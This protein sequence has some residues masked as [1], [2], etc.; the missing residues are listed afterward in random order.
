MF[1]KL[2]S[3][4][5]D[6][7]IADDWQLRV[8]F[9]DLLVLADKD[10]VVDMTAEAIARRTNV[11]PAIVKDRLAKLEAP[12]PTSRTP[13]CEGR[14]ITRIDAHRDWGWQITNFMKYRES[15]NKE[16]LRMSEADRK[17]TYRS[18]FH[19]APSPVPLTPKTEIQREKQNSPGSVPDLSGTVPPQFNPVRLK[20]YRREY[21]ADIKD[22]Q[23]AIRKVEKDKASYARD[24]TGDTCDLIAFLEKEKPDG[25]EKRITEAKAKPS[26]YERTSLK[27]AA[28]D[29]VEAWKARIAELRKAMAGI[30]N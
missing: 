7:S 13:A 15:A 25:W 4:I 1:V 17:R 27:P 6:S 23:D 10:G 3:S 14:R 5:F 20:Q 28:A 16:M 29:I 2:F 24:M 21:E 9:Q 8:V 11:P 18:K 26:A 19:R 30:K 12:D 22:S